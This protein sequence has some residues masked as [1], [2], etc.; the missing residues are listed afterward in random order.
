[1]PERQPLADERAFQT[2]AV[3][4]GLGVDDEIIGV[5]L[6]HAIHP[7]HVDDDPAMNRHRAAAHSRARAVGHDRHPRGARELDDLAHLVDGLGPHD[8]VRRVLARRAGPH[9]Q[10]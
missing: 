2:L 3:D 10:E 9:G 8:D 5:H 1:M 4:A 7:L 6:Q